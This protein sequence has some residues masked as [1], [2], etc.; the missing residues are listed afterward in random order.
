GADLDSLDTK[1]SKLAHDALEPLIKLESAARAAFYFGTVR[2]D[3][4][5]WRLVPATRF[6]ALMAE[7]NG[8][9]DK[10]SDATENLVAMRDELARD[11]RRRVGAK[12]A[13][14]NPFVTASELRANYRFEIRQMPVA[15]PTGL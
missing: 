9:R 6:A 11:Y 15:D 5:A 4:N 7:L 2:W 13:A 3:D 1:V 14:E 12:L 10:Y 8:Y